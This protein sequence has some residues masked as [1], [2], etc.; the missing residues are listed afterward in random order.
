M[1]KKIDKRTKEY[2]E[3]QKQQEIV[4]D[5]PEQE[6]IQFSNAGLDDNK[7]TSYLTVTPAPNPEVEALKAEMAEM[8]KQSLSDMVEMK[9]MLKIIGESS[10][11]N[12]KKI[13]ASDNLKKN[14]KLNRYTTHHPQDEELKALKLFFDESAILISHLPEL[15][16][17]IL[18]DFLRKNVAGL[19]FNINK[20]PNLHK[21]ALKVGIC[22]DDFSKVITPYIAN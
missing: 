6:M 1:D 7:H 9:K 20:E 17:K 3:L 15:K 13:E 4:T 12:S 22:T 19:L 18:L 8:R 21:R 10:V 14:R 5:Q 11:K 2:K 16:G